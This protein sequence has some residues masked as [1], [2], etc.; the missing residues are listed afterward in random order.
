MSQD[1]LTKNQLCPTTVLSFFTNLITRKQSHLLGLLILFVSTG[2]GVCGQ[3]TEAKLAMF[4]KFVNGEVPIKEATV[5]R[6]YSATNRTVPNK[7][8]WRFG[9]QNDTWYVQR[10]IPEVT[11]SSKLVPT[12][13]SVVCGA[14]Y[15]QFWVVADQSLEFVTKKFVSGSH[16]EKNSR[17][18]RS[19]MFGALSLGVP[20]ISQAIDLAE[21]PVKWD[22]LAFNTVVVAKRDS[23]GAVLT[24]APLAGQLK[25]G[26]N[27]LPSSAEFPGVG[28]FPGGSIVYEYAEDTVGIPKGF[29]VSYPDA[30]VRFTFLSL[31]LGSNDLTKTDGYMPSLFAD[32]KVKRIVTLY[33]NE[34]GYE[35]GDG[36]SY[37]S[38]SAPEP[39]LGGLAPELRGT[40]WLNSPKPLTLT[41]LRGKV[42]LIDF[43]G[44]DCVPCIEA[45][46]HT[47]AL[48]NKFKNQGL[49]AI[50][51]CYNWGTKKRVKALLK[52]RNITFPNMM[53]LDLAIADSKDGYTTWNYVLDAYPSY[54]LID[55]SGNLVWK[56]KASKEPTE[57]QIK[58]L[59][60]SQPAK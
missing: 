18:D 25:L 14:S 21:A 26:A 3:A 5:Y 55:K 12:R 10:L 54:A 50:G 41:G 7:E 1:F 37:P 6:E 44:V 13:V 23:K 34:L 17:F 57:S 8:W 35:Q 15:T 43:W 2:A 20:R 28:Q 19:L 60:E 11:N 49:I 22:G 48:Y 39:K 24:T 46:P 29:V 40:V 32:M 58:E 30:T 52:N 56:S 42:V 38:F 27:G 45:L 59:L 16:P 31:T 47:E 4:Q 9:R 36:K 53:D 33:T 51:V